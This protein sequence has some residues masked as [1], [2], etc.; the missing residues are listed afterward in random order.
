[1]THLSYTGKKITLFSQLPSL[2]FLKEDFPACLCW[3]VRFVWT[4]MLKEERVDAYLMVSIKILLQ[5]SVKASPCWFF[6]NG[7][8]NF[9]LKL[10]SYER[11][12]GSTSIWS[13][14]DSEHQ[15]VSAGKQVFVK[16]NLHSTMKSFWLSPLSSFPAGKFQIKQIF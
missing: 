16:R 13:E 1:M 3:S 7:W 8:E 2:C 10:T 9:F 6:R 11:L 4:W 12:H 15:F 14:G 5:A